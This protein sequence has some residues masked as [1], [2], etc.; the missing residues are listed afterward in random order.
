[1]TLNINSFKLIN[2]YIYLSFNLKNELEYEVRVEDVYIKK[3][4]Y[5]REKN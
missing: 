4:E 2:K 1:L 5:F 3:K